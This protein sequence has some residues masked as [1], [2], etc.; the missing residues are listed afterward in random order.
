MERQ[1]FDKHTH[2]DFLG[3]NAKY[4]HST[5][6]NYSHIYTHTHTQLS[7]LSL[8]A[9]NVAALIAPATGRD[10]SSVVACCAAAVALGAAALCVGLLG[11]SPPLFA[12]ARL[13]IQ[14]ILH[15]DGETKGVVQLSR[16]VRDVGVLN[17]IVPLNVVAGVVVVVVVAVHFPCNAAAAGT[18]GRDAASNSLGLACLD[19]HVWLL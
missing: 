1:A 15:G 2:T 6:T 19:R 13:R 16:H 3:L 8:D 18:G 14:C 12:L 4:K 5:H 17:N 7:Q 11:K 9:R 10:E